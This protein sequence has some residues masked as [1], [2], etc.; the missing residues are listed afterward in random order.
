MSWLDRPSR[1]HR[2]GLHTHGQKLLS[3]RHIG[4]IT[5]PV[6]TGVTSLTRDSTTGNVSWYSISE[7]RKEV[8]NWD[9][10]WTCVTEGEALKREDTVRVC[11]S[12]QTRTSDGDIRHSIR[13][14]EAGAR[15]L[16][17]GRRIRFMSTNDSLLFRQ[18]ET[19]LGIQTL[20]RES[21]GIKGTD[22]V[23]RVRQRGGA[24]GW[25]RV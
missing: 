22:E 1:I 13:A 2:V 25:C 16:G 24:E 12:E 23:W 5:H 6:S 3:A 21:E 20:Y 19:I 14:V 7:V 10:C 4:N 8:T 18:H 11:R 15:C 17:M 9:L